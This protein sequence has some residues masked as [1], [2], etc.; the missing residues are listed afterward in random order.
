MKNIVIKVIKVKDSAV[1]PTYQT[2]HSAGMDLYACLDSPITL[3]SLERIMI[4]TGLMIEIPIGYEAQ[5]RARSGLAI[6][7]GITIINPIGTIDADYRGEVGILIV[8]L[9]N[10]AFT[11]EPGMRIAQMVI[12]QYEHISWEEVDSLSETERGDGGFGSTGI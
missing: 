2:E 11:I 7:Y 6:K 8:N 10:E 5:I 3:K 9:S 4:P 12:A 1:I